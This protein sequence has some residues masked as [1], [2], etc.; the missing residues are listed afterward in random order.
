MN[1]LNFSLDVI[2]VASQLSL[3]EVISLEFGYVPFDPKLD[4]GEILIDRTNNKFYVNIPLDRCAEKEV[5][6]Y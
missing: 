5:E 6:L 2:N 1:F 3:S 4:I